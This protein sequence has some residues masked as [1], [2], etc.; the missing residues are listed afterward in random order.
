MMNSSTIL[1]RSRAGKGS[2]RLQIERLEERRLLANTVGTIINT[3]EAYEGYTLFSPQFATTSYLVDLEGREVNRWE[4]DLPNSAAY[5]Q[6]NGDLLRVVRLPSTANTLNAPGAA[7]RVELLDW[8]GNLK[9]YYELNTPNFRLHHDIELMPNGNILLIAWERYTRGES[10]AEGRDPNLRTDNNGEVWPDVIFELQ[11]D[12]AGGV[13]GDIVWKWSIWDHLIQQYDSTK[14]NFGEVAAHPELIDLNYVP[15]GVGAGAIAADWTHFNAIDYNPELD[16]IIVSSREFSE[17]WVID[18]STTTAEAASGSGGVYG[19]GGNLLFRWGNPRAYNQGVPA[20]QLLQYQHDAQWI[21]PGLDG[22]GNFLVFNNGWNRPGGA[23]YSSVE[24]IAPPTRG[25]RWLLNNRT[26]GSVSDLILFNTQVLPAGWTPIVGDWNGDGFDTSGFFDPLGG[27]FFLNNSRNGWDASSVI[28]FTTGPLAAGVIPLTGDWDNSGR[29]TPGF[30]DPATQTF[31]LSNSTTAWVAEPAFAATTVSAR[32]LPIAG[33]WN[34]DGVDTV[35]LYDPVS[36]NWQLANAALAWS[37]INPLPAPSPV[38]A[39]WLPIAGDWNGNG[40]DGVGLYDPEANRWFLNNRIDGSATDLITINAPDVPAVYIPL[41]GDWNKSGR[42]TVGLYDPMYYSVQDTGEFGPDDNLWEYTGTPRSSF[43]GNIVSGAQRLANGNTLINVGPSGRF[44]EINPAGAIVWEYVNPV[45]RDDRVLTQGQTV[46]DDAPSGI[47]G[48]KGNLTFRAY[49][50]GLNYLDASLDVTPGGVIQRGE[51]APPVLAPIG[52]QSLLAGASSGTLR[53]DVTDFDT[54]I[55]NLTFTGQVESQL[56]LLDRNLSLNN[57]NGPA[58]FG[59]YYENFRGSH[60]KYLLN[61]A[62]AHPGNRWYYVLPDGKFYRFTGDPGS[63]APSSLQGVLIADVGVAVYDNPALLH[64]ALSQPGAIAF[65]FTEG[66]NPTFSFDADANAAGVYAATVT[67]SDGELSDD[68]TFSIHVT[69]VVTSPPLLDPIADQ[70]LTVGNSTASIVLGV[71]DDDTPIESLV[72][73]GEA[74]SELY[75]LDQ[76][77]SLNNPQARPEFGAYFENFR[78]SNERYFLNPA[79]VHPAN[80]WYYVLP[81]GDFYRF[82]GD[83]RSSAPSSLQGELLAN[84]GAAVYNNPVL[85]HNAV[86]QPGAITFAFTPGATTTLS[87]SANVSVSGEYAA[88]V[89]VTDGVN[90]AKTPFTVVVEPSGTLSAHPNLLISAGVPGDFDG[91]GVVETADNLLWRELY[92]SDDLRADGN[93]DGL[94]NAADYSLW[95]DNL[96]LSSPFFDTPT[97][98]ITVSGATAP[99]ATVVSPTTNQ[100]MRIAL[101]PSTGSISRAETSTSLPARS[102]QTFVPLRRDSLLLAAVFA[103]VSETSE[104]PTEIDFLDDQTVEVDEADDQSSDA[105]FESLMNYFV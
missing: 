100:P 49:R 25:Q 104:A 5:L 27:E 59:N 58:Q 47:P 68:V 53:I 14:A 90:T 39:D 74:E 35:G 51:V 57:P 64:N 69:A 60:E 79:G 1:H 77:L 2:S 24:E 101:P 72:F 7:G 67:A 37:L 65:T 8:D 36:N 34:G 41:A 42:D 56:Y 30:Y 87:L 50:Y 23:N 20:D 81:N 85:L 86:S 54:P 89:S 93:G 3:S 105:A 6:P 15:T 22:A 21:E 78:G 38:P 55:Q 82:T 103:Q 48:V 12:Y 46:P 16:Q 75:L 9:W 26:D 98:Q 102:A 19:M 88:V 31:V 18:H 97:S 83:P 92:G 96:G 70:N 40:R 13:G 4:S 11:P 71:S 61:P 62:G 63:S 28:S 95:R 76:E 32:W 44:F 43:Y 94:V 45:I 10:I 99:V 80:R 52:D 73:T 84:V 17:F 33:D 91:N 66:M 29:D